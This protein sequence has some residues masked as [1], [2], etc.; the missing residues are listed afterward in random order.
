MN[1]PVKQEPTDEQRKMAAEFVK[2]LISGKTGQSAYKP[3]IKALAEI[4]I[5]PNIMLVTIGDEPTECVVIPTQELMVK[6]YKHMT[7]IDEI[8]NAL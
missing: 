7:T 8:G 5:E 2:H 3:I 6:E 1:Q 4:G